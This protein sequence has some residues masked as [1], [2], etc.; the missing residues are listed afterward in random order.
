MLAT[1]SLTYTLEGQELIKDISLSFSPGILYGILGPNGAG[2]STFL[3]LLT[4]IWKPTMGKILWNGENLLQKSRREVSRIISLVPQNAQIL[5]DF[6]VSQMVAMGRYPHS[7]RLLIS[8][9][10][11]IIENALHSVDIWHLRHKQVNHLSNGERQRVYIARSLVTES[12]IML[13][14]EPTA[15]LDIRHQLEIWELLKQ[16]LSQG[17]IIIVTNHDLAITEH[18]C[19]HVTVLNRG[20][21][22]ANGEFSKVIDSKLLADVFGVKRVLSAN[23]KLFELF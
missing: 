12:P 15:S 17:K 10:Q 22:I 8:K 19:N 14:D 21:C 16:L 1:E 23:S 3:K 2:K 18:F 9:D 13:L 5:F 6:S 11:E 4:G 7:C 20:K